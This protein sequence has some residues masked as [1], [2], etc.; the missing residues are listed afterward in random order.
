MTQYLCELDARSN[1]V[2]T[3]MAFAIAPNT[4][5]FSEPNFT[6]TLSIINMIR[7]ILQISVIRSA[8]RVLRVYGDLS[9]LG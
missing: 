9:L 4:R 7:F 5:V 2:G 8:L 3:F 6:K 1:S